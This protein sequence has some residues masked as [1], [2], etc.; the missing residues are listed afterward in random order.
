[1][2][3]REIEKKFGLPPLT[4]V[5]S[6][7][8]ALPDEKKLRLVKGV[9]DS[10]AKVKGSPEELKTLLELIKIIVTASPEQISA[11]KDITANLV[12]LAKY[13]PK[14]LK[15]LPLKEIVEEVRK[16]S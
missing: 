7:L 14:D 15:Q 6:V 16:G 12:K 11:V 2:V 5:A 3:F 4:E 1:M 8:K 13:L 9:I 10:A